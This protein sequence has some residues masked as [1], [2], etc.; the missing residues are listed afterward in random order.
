MARE[1]LDLSEGAAQSV[2]VDRKG[3]TRHEKINPVETMD[4]M[5]MIADEI[6]QIDNEIARLTNQRNEYA[7]EFVKGR[8]ILDSYLKKTT[9]E[10]FGE[11]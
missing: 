10:L 9:E 7:E 1:V 2:Y 8:E 5:S 11:I 6:R 4:R 3:E